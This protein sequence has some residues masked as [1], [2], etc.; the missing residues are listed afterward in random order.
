VTILGQDDIIPSAL[1][2]DRLILT[3]LP[4]L[5]IESQGEVRVRD[6]TSET[7]RRREVEG[8][9]ESE[10]LVAEVGVGVEKAR[11]RVEVNRQVISNNRVVLVLVIHLLVMVI[12]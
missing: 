6:R 4:G 12:C 8:V 3:S 5:V 7:E 9:E 11:V 10:G 2:A 1:G